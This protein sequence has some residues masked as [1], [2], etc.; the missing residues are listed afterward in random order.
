MKWSLIV[1]SSPTGSDAVFN[2]LRLA[3]EAHGRGHKVRL[4]LVNDAV[5]AARKDFT[6]EE[7]RDLLDGCVADALPVKVCTTCVNRCGISTGGVREDVA[8]AG[9]ADLVAWIEDADRVLTF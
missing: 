8:L 9:M 2:A 1:S 5:D 3:R 6:G 4:F 7:V